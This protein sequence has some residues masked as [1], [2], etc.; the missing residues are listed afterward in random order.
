MSSTKSKKKPGKQGFG[1]CQDCGNI[2]LP[3]RRTNTLYCRICDKDYPMD[4][5]LNQYKKVERKTAS[6]KEKNKKQI[7]K[8]AIIEETKKGPSI[9]EEERA[10]YEDLFEASDLS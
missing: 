1:F 9:S 2:L 3:K 5:G 10:A 7:L 6:I 8:T 4:K